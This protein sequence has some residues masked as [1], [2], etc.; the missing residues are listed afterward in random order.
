MIPDT[1][2][3]AGFDKE[4]IYLYRSSRHVEKASKMVKSSTAGV[5]RTGKRKTPDIKGARFN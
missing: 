1:E 4:N 2:S 3:K 5:R